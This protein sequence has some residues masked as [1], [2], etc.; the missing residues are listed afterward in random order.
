MKKNASSAPHCQIMFFSQSFVI[1]RS[2]RNQKI[3]KKR[4]RKKRRKQMS[5][6]SLIGVRL[7]QRYLKEKQPKR[8]K[9]KTLIRKL[10]HSMQIHV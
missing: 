9:E 10:N 5:M 2:S 7:I 4:K 3:K 6:S 1:L 8:R